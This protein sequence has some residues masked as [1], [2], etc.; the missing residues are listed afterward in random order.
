MI[1]KLRLRFIISALFSI[2]L[3]LAATIAAINISN[4][5]RAE[6]DT[7]T[8][9]DQVEDRERESLVKQNSFDY[10][11][12]QGQGQGGQ[13]GGWGGQQGQPGGQ[14]QPGGQGG[15]G[16]QPGQGGEQ[17]EKPNEFHFTESDPSKDDPRGQY[18]ITVFNTDGSVEYTYFHMISVDKESDQQMAI[19]VL[20][21]KKT[22]GKIGNYSYKV[23]TKTDYAR[24][25]YYD[26]A[27]GSWNPETMRWETPEIDEKVPFTATYV[28]F[29]DTTES[30]QSLGNWLVTS[31][32]IALV[33]YA[34]IAALIIISSHFVFR[35]SEES[36]RK[37]KAFI[38]NASHEL[39]TPLTIINTDVEILKMDHGEN[40]WTD[41][42][43]DQVRRLTMMTNQLVTLSKLDEANLQNYPFTVFSISQL[44]KESVDAFLPTYEKS[45]FKF[46]SEIDEDIDVRANK[47]LINELF[48][49]FLDNAL[50]Y[51]T[52]NGEIVFNLKKTN[53]NKL[54]ILFSNDTDDTEVD[55]NQ[56]FER[57][58][59]SPR[60][61]KK[62]GSGI[63]LSIAREII[64]LHKGKINASIK[65][66]KIFFNISF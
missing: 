4:Y 59:R 34:V 45:G 60:N 46:K 9:L 35:T 38:T 39:K 54:E 1:K 61:S 22:K 66:G 33:S 56:L 6:R 51:T 30:R 2:F 32:V 52:S 44:A 16:G 63:G 40:E 57:F 21:S 43:A 10:T 53:K 8:L 13:Q 12:G 47:Y 58:Y 24:Q 27:N 5:V 26:Y 50:K 23:D 11:T 31:I 14:S 19:D 17:P 7:A 48:Y 18:F 3:V 29:V 55:V 65:D 64:E 20:A 42:I 28:V 49:I 41:S 37:Q 25:H 62:E 36:Y 15:E